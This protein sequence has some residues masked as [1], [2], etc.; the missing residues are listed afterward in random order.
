MPKLRAWNTPRK[1]TKEVRAPQPDTILQPGT[2]APGLTLN[3]TP[4]ETL[5]RKQ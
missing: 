1:P 4:T 3:T 5:S 2:K